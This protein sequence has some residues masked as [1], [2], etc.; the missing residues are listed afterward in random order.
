MPGEMTATVGAVH[1]K[2]DTVKY[3][4]RIHLGLPEGFIA[5][6]HMV[7]KRQGEGELK[8]AAL[9]LMAKW[10]VI[11]GLLLMAKLWFARQCQQPTEHPS[12]L[13]TMA[14]VS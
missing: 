4:R 7:I 9:L 12:C 8:T 14:R 6:E 3:N 1:V 2:E 13:L 5:L 11:N 10:F